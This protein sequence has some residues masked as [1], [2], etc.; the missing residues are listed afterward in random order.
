MHSLAGAMTV[1]RRF[2]MS[3]GPQILRLVMQGA[4]EQYLAEEMKRVERDVDPVKLEAMFVPGDPASLQEFTLSQ[5]SLYLEMALE[6]AGA[7]ESAQ[8]FKMF[9]PGARVDRLECWPLKLHEDEGGRELAG[10]IV[11]F[12]EEVIARRSG[13]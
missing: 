2:A 5:P 7:D 6:I 9:V 4:D 12:I 8:I 13:D 11:P 3:S 1:N 10:K